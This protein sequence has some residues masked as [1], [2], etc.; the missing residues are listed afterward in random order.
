MILELDKAEYSKCRNLL[1]EQG[2][3]EAIA[4]VERI[5]PGR[6]FVDNINNPAS[7]LIWLGNNDG[8]IFFGSEQNEGFN[9][10]LNHFINKVII[11][12]AK[13]VQLK[14]FEGIG[15]HE[16]WDNIIEKVFEHRKLDTWN[17]RVYSL[18]LGD[19]KGHSE[20]IIDQGYK[21]IKIS[22]TVLENS[23]NSIINIGF[24]QSKILDFWSSTETFISKGMGYCII[25]QNEVVSICFSGFVVGNVHC[26][27]IET[28]E[29]H[30]RKKLAQRVVHSFVKDCL[31]KNIVPY[32]DCM[33]M[34]KPSVAVAENM[35]FGNIFN[36]VGYQFL[37][38]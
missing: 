4:V 18:Q 21:V 7:G 12:E 1:N 14:W 37:L 24:L 26:I 19:Y 9:N 13:K 10:G 8:F 27:D 35:G 28:L 31:K 15:N 38:E 34:N 23:D 30:Q 22:D 5:N 20:P 32:W 3:L 33:E 6:I 17:Q 11:P 25:H 29:A 2:Q 16:K 36:Y